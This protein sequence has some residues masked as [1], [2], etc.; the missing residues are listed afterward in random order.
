MNVLVTGAFRCAQQQ[1]DA[2]AQ[3]GHQVVFMQQESESLPVDPAWVEGVVCNGLFLHHDISHFVNL[4]FIQLTSAG[5]DRV[6]MEEVNRREI[7]ICNARGVYGIPM[8]EFAVA[9]VLQLYKQ[10]RF[11]AENQKNHGWNKHRGLLEL[12]GKQVTIVGCG[13]IG[14]ECAKRFAAFD[15][16]VVGVDIFEAELPNIQKMYHISRLGEVLPDSDVVVLTLPL[17]EETKHLFGE[18]AF[19]AMKKGAILVNIAR[20]GVVDTQAL[21]RALQGHLGGAVLDVFEEEPLSADSPLWDMEQVLL[22]PHNSFVGDH[23][24]QRLEAVILK[25]LKECSK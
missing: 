24:S 15:C 6:P 2:I 5:F 18:D 7:R 10:S 12:C 16:R 8:A 23:N 14:Q 11:F 25:N 22:T 20:G 4:R 13:N 1:L 17:T 19:A 9:G 3:L 21:I